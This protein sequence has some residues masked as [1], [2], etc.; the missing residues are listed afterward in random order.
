MGNAL[1]LCESGL[2]DLREI[3]LG[4]ADHVTYWVTIG[5]LN[6]DGRPDIVTTNSDGPNMV[7]VNET[8]R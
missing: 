4:S 2:H 1:Y 5:D 7:H 8:H 6:G 3:R